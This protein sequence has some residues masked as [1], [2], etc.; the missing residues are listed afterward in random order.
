M[1]DSNVDGDGGEVDGDGDGVD[2]MALGALPRPGRV[3]EQRILSPKIGLQR[4]R[5]YGTFL[6][7]TPIYLEFLLRRLY[8][9]EGAMSEGGQSTHTIGWRAQGD[10]RHHLVWLPLAPLRL[11][12]GLRLVLGENRNFGLRFVQFREYFLCNFS[13]TQKQ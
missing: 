13:E 6:G 5:R 11:F 2:E 1:G 9:G 7:K 4:R 8:I 10:P 12:F 3:P